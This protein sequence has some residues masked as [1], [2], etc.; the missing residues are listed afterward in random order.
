ML[1][2]DEKFLRFNTRQDEERLTQNFSTDRKA[3]HAATAKSNDEENKVPENTC[4]AVINFFGIGDRKEN[5]SLS[6]NLMNV[7]VRRLTCF[8]SLKRRS[9]LPIGGIPSRKTT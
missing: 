4:G 3:I 1:Q 5:R 2:S 8:P 9:T 7:N 6:R